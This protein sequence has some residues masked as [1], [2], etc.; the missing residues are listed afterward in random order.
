MAEKQSRKTFLK[1]IGLTLGI[2]SVGPALLANTSSTTNEVVHLSTDEKEMLFLYEKWLEEFNAFVDKRNENPFDLENNKRLMEI[3]SQSK[4]WEEQLR[5]Y[6][7]NPYFEQ[8][9]A[10]LTNTVS[11]KIS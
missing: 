6:M 7:K 1:K 4:E 11:N 10:Q 5:E 9:H 8:L 3:T 2:A